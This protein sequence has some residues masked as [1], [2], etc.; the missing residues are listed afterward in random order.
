MP[1]RRID[2]SHWR[3]FLEQVTHD[4]VDSGAQAEVAY[5]PLRCRIPEK[6]LSLFGLNYDP[7]LDAIEVALDGVDHMIDAPRELWA[8]L[9]PSGLAALEIVGPDHVSQIVRLRSP[10]PVAAVER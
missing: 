4:L 8:D 9:G 6:W 2:K 3:S 5:L 7:R 10:L 1:T